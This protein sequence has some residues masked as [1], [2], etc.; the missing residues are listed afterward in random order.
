MSKIPKFFCEFCGNE[1]KRNTKICPHCGRFF[2][3][4]K[5]PQC[6]FTGAESKFKGGCPKCG[7]AVHKGTRQKETKKSKKRFSLRLSR[8]ERGAQINISDDERLPLW[9]Y[10]VVFGMLV[11][12]IFLPILK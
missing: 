4:I 3:S 10:L 1:V 6:G 11:L 2:A 5:C 9:I 7:Y 12:V 8:S